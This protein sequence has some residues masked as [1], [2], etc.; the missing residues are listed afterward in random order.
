MTEVVVD[1][2][3]VGWKGAL[4]TD[5]ALIPTLACDKRLEPTTF[6]AYTAN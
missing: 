5:A 6:T 1:E 2:T 4:D 3:F